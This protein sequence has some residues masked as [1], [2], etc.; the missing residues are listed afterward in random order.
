MIH[1]SLAYMD[2]SLHISS[3][4]T[5][6]KHSLP[7][8]VGTVPNATQLV[9]LT[10]YPQYEPERG[11]G[12]NEIAAR[13]IRPIQNLGSQV[14]GRMKSQARMKAQAHKG[15]ADNVRTHPLCSYLVSSTYHHTRNIAY[16]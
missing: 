3:S 7:T 14:A 11:Q 6:M 10:R 4:L 12:K 16:I 15:N 9:C 5:R 13:R 1:A 8:N 2:Q